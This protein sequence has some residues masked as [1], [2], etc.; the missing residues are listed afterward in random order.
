MVSHFKFS[1]FNPNFLP[2]RNA[3]EDDLF[4]RGE[5]PRLYSEGLPELALSNS[6]YADLVWVYQ[7]V[8]FS[9]KH[10]PGWEV[11][12]VGSWTRYCSHIISE[13][14]REKWHSQWMRVSPCVNSWISTHQIGTFS[15]RYN[16]YVKVKTPGAKVIHLRIR[17]IQWWRHCINT[18]QMI[19][20]WCRQKN[21]TRYQEL[22]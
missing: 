6:H 16:G 13:T 22:W 14:Y 12:S 5:R 9:L 3:R 17:I 8:I 2:H 4:G 18:N 7:L 21:L 15:A 19:A 11:L 10:R 1:Y 20:S